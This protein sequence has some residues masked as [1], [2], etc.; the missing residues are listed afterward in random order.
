MSEKKSENSMPSVLGALIT[1]SVV[2]HWWP[3][4]IPWQF[5]HFWAST[6]TVSEWCSAVWPIFVWGGA[7]SAVSA[8]IAY[9]GSPNSYMTRMFRGPSVGDMLIGGAVTS[10]IAGVVEEIL[11][12]WL[13]FFSSLG[14]VIFLN[15]L[16]FGFAGFGLPHWFHMNVW[17]PLAD[18]TTGGYLHAQIFDPR[19]W[20]IGAAMLAA[21]ATFRDGHKYQGILGVLNSWFI[22]MLLFWVM[23]TYGLPAAIFIHFAYDLVVFS[24]R[25]L[26]KLLFSAAG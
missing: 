9:S 3:E 22:G 2:Y 19:G 8:I 7:L 5:S 26:V 15:F 11:F 20:H 13:F 4:L 18:W 14:G 6:G 25:P 10:V 23:F 17:G 12:R 21:N 1:I 24:T 16:F